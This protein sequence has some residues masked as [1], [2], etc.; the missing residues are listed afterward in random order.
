MNKQNYKIKLVG[1]SVFGECPQLWKTL[2][3]EARL[4]VSKDWD[5]GKKLKLARN[6]CVG[7]RF[8]YTT[9]RVG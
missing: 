7:D 3:E 9:E 6:I 8:I 4:G 1:E 5:Y 2:I